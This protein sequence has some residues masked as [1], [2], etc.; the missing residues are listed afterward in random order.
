MDGNTLIK[1]ANR[2]SGL[3]GYV[4]PD[5]GNLRRTFEPR[6]EKEISFE[7]LKKLSYLPGGKYILENCLVIKNEEAVS[8]LIGDVELEYFYDEEQVKDLLLNGS[9]EQFLDCLDFAPDGV[10]ECVKDLAV[11]LPLN[12][13]SK[14]EAILRKTGFDVNKAV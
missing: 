10:I 14:R 12:D 1:V 13:V 8:E 5:L 2:D 7:E 11:K 6:E 9:Y 4:I 3:V